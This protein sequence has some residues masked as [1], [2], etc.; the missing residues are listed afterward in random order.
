MN[1]ITISYLFITV[2]EQMEN[3]NWLI[4]SHM[5]TLAVDSLSHPNHTA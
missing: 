4:L 1:P 5:P 2:A 3:A